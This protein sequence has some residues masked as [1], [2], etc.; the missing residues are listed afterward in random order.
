MSWLYLS[1]PCAFFCYPLHTVKRVPPAPGLPCALSSRRANEI[2]KLRRKSRRENESVCLP[3][4]SAVIA[5]LAAFAEASASRVRKP[6]RSLGGDGTGRPS[7][8]ETSVIEPKGRGVLDHPL[9]AFAEATAAQ[10][11]NPG[12]ALAETGRG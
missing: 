10:D 6:R 5:R 2:A 11:R 9:A 4:Y 8:P 12:E 1:N 3:S 7:I